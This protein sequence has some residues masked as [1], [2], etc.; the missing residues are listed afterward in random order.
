[1]LADD[2]LR[3]RLGINGR[4]RVEEHFSME[5]YGERLVRVLERI[6]E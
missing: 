4:R 5:V 1:M 2:D 3:K 6:V